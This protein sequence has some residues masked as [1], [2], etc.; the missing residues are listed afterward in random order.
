MAK[1]IR[2]SRNLINPEQDRGQ[3]IYGAD[4]EDI[5]SILD[6]APYGVSINETVGDGKV[7][8]INHEIFNLMGY[9]VSEIPTGRVAQ[10]KFSPDR[11]DQRGANKIEKDLATSGKAM[12]TH[13]VISKDG[14][15]RF[16]E[17]RA[18]LLPNKKVV[19]MCTDVTRRERAEA[20]L[21]ESESKFRTLFKKS[22]DA[23]FLFEGDKIIDYNRAAERM[24]LKKDQ[25]TILETTLARLS[26]QKQPD[27][28]V[29]SKKA[30]GIFTL[31]LKKKSLRFEWVLKRFNGDVFPVEATV[32]KIK[33]QGKQILH[34]IIRDISAWK[35]AEKGLLRA[36]EEL[37]DRVKERTSELRAVNKELLKEIRI[38]EKA[39]KEVENSR[40]ELR[41]LSEH[42]QRAREEE[43]TRIAR[44][45][46]DELGQTLSALK[47]DVTQFRKNLSKDH[48]VSSNQTK[49]MENQIDHA[50]HSVR[51]L[52]SELRPP[53][54]EDFG[55]PA[56]IEWYL[57][58]Y[59]KR[60]G[61]HCNAKIDSV[62]PIQENGFA[63]MLFRILQEAMT[64]ILRHTGATRVNVNL[65]NDQ[66]TLMLKV[67]DNGRGITKSQVEDP[68][69]FGITGIR[70]R[71]RFWGGQ[72]EFIGIPNK[73]TTM[74]V[75][76]PIDQKQRGKD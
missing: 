76:I 15:T 69:S 40:E 32:T 66:G 25:N 73:G 4:R 65:K 35:A 64:N 48:D 17:V 7:L 55:L 12:A 2:D 16:I 9:T 75:S 70:E 52:C 46:H 20:E 68:R 42:L 27:G 26:P 62:F 30:K 67:K 47:I 1:K 34:V 8:Y 3:W 11:K 53:I 39:E 74:T 5:I 63:L 23:V 72:S 61:I 58:E 54:L 24:L 37:E 49:S 50:I 33:L 13:K 19:S 28:L 41:Y 31:A 10:K 59:Q 22:P 14:K 29:S 56:A 36:K 43:R 21:R 57:E 45:V 38:R 51:H 71:V 44:E 60:T 6:N 18:A